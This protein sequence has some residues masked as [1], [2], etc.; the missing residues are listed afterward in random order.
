MVKLKNVS[1]PRSN[2]EW[3]QG[4][5][6]NRCVR[7]VRIVL[8][9]LACSFITVKSSDEVNAASRKFGAQETDYE[10]Y[11][12][13]H[14]LTKERLDVRS[15]L[16]ESSCAIDESNASCRMASD[17]FTPAFRQ[18]WRIWGVPEPTK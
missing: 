5:D 1:H 17:N 12:E 2:T 10:K 15:A 4:N 11:C 16:V 6:E 14:R 8:W 13:D 3:L 18:S 9:T 7:Y